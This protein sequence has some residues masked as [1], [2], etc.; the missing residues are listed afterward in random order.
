M[1]EKQQLKEL[2]DQL[3]HPKGNMGVET[4][5]QMNESNISM[6]LHSMERLNLN[7]NEKVMELGHG[8]CAH[9]PFLM[10][11]GVIYY[12]LEV[13]ELMYAEATKMHPAAIAQQ[14]AFF[15]LYDGI[16]IPFETDFFDKIFRSEEHTSELQS[17][18]HLVCRLLLEKKKK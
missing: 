12:G 5:N 7:T 3:S 14:R 1:N 17:R 10:E 18:P 4:G 8:N 16:N 13:S 6:T 2:A 9:L 15:E 11:K